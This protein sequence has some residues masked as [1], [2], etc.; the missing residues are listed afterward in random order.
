MALYEPTSW[1]GLIIEGMTQ[2]ITG[3]VYLTYIFLMVIFVVMLVALFKIEFQW[4]LLSVT[5][6][7]L[8]LLAYSAEWLPFFG[9]LTFLVAVLIARHFIGGD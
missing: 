4:V 6:I 8:T 9:M 2:N 1:L 7:V 3:N 5:G